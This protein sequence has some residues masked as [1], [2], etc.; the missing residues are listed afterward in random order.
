LKHGATKITKIN[1]YLISV[2]EL[3]CPYVHGDNLHVQG[4]YLLKLAA[5]NVNYHL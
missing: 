2:A 3:I 5:I 4:G 1:S